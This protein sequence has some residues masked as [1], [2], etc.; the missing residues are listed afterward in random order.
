M[1][2]DKKLK[3]QTLQFKEQL[4]IDG[5]VKGGF[6][7]IEKCHKTAGFHDSKSMFIVGQSG[8]G[9][10][11]IGKGYWHRFP[12][13]DHGDHTEKEVI[14]CGLP[15]DTS[16][17]GLLQYLLN[18]TGC[19]AASTN[20][21]DAMTLRFIKRARDVHC[22]V[23]VVD[24]IHH[25]LPEHTGTKTQIFA[26]L[27]K[28]LI[29]ELNVAFIFIGLPE[30]TRLLQAMQKKDANKDQ[31]KRRFRRTINSEAFQPN[32]KAWERTLATYQEALGVPC[33]NLISDEMQKRF[34]LATN[35]LHG[36]V[37]NILAEAL[38]EHKGPEMISLEELANAYEE[39]TSVF[40]IPEHPFRISNAE[41]TRL[42]W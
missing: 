14:Y 9:K 1:T 40:D 28:H 23:I 16:L 29:D 36:G 11:H 41:L 4:F 3:D 17:K 18:A 2:S 26:D 22:R 8:V 37:A 5:R 6:A 13:I 32:S 15:S 7:A 42:T 35:G 19:T 30:S 10:S 27:F 38:E 31:L 34:Y 33:V 20:S 25:L 12:D 39:A 24:E 21:K